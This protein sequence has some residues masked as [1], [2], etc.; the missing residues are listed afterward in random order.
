[1]LDER[2]TAA[3]LVT[4]VAD[5]IEKK[6]APQLDAHTAFHAKVAVNALHIVIRELQSG[7]AVAAADG[8]RLAALTG[9]AAEAGLPEQNKALCGLI[10]REEIDG[11]DPA[12]HAHLMQSVLARIAIDSPKYPSIKAVP[13]R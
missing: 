11:D 10:D 12:L 13:E 8:V 4:A 1:M 3:E 5:F 2:P 7:A 6:V 9:V